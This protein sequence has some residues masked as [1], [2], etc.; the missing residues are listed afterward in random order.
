METAAGGVCLT[1]GGWARGPE[2]HGHSH[3]APPETGA[4]DRPRVKRKIISGRQTAPRPIH[5]HLDTRV[6]L[7]TSSAER[8]TESLKGETIE[9][10]A[11]DRR[12]ATPER[13]VHAT[14]NLPLS[15]SGSRPPRPSPAALAVADQVDTRHPALHRPVF[16]T[17]RLRPTDGDRVLLDSVHRQVPAVPVRLQRWCLAMALAGHVLR[18]LRPGYRQVSTV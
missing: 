1:L 9:R 2:R 6:D 12:A 7:D 14:G 5:L 8:F 4:G 18:P 11:A 16:P 15:R 10:L 17:H 13:S 3:R